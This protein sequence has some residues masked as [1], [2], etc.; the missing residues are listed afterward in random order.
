MILKIAKLG[1]PLLRKRAEPVPLDLIRN[2]D[3]Q[4]FMDDLIDTMHRLEGVGI[5]APQVRVSKQVFCVEC[6]ESRRYPGTPNIPLYVVLNPRLRIL[7][8]KK[9]TSF[10]GCLSVPDIRGP[11]PRARRVHLTGL[12]RRG[13]PLRVTA[14]GFHARILQH[15]M[16]HLM[17]RV[18]LDRMKD[19]KKLSFM[20]YL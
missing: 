9:T 14:S 4:S 7:D 17:G 19:M 11:V 20:E 8:A 15:E 12:D 10:E 18:Y 5:A 1:H 16:D 13:K 3:F 6:V 2:K